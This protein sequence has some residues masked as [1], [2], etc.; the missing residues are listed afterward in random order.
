MKGCHRGVDEEH[1]EPGAPAYLVQLPDCLGENT[2]QTP[3]ERS[4]NLPLV[5]LQK[6]S[7][8]GAFC[9]YLKQCDWESYSRH[10]L[11][12]QVYLNLHT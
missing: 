6:S 12:A 11:N 7:T 4:L 8:G 5:P 9:V 2:G 10:T 1:M 3:P